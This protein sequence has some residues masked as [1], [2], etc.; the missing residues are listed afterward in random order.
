MSCKVKNAVE[1][2]KERETKM[3]SICNLSM[4]GYTGYAELGYRPTH[5]WLAVVLAK[6]GCMDPKE[7]LAILKEQTPIALKRF[8]GQLVPH[9]YLIAGWAGMRQDGVERGYLP[10]LCWVSN[11][12]DEQGNLRNLPARSFGHKIVV[13]A[14]GDGG[15]N[16][17]CIGQ[18]VRVDRVSA[19]RR[20]VGEAVSRNVGPEDVARLLV[21][22][23]QHTSKMQDDKR[24]TVGAKVSAC[25]IPRASVDQHFRGAGSA[26]MSV[27]EARVGGWFAYYDPGRD[28]FVGYAPTCTCDGWATYDSAYRA[29][30]NGD[31]RMELKFLHVPK[32]GEPGFGKPFVGLNLVEGQP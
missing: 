15:V 18:P 11:R 14:P 26:I 27:P 16:L 20:V 4:I 31:W 29:E 6:R 30:A 25:C 9:E 7:A 5:E 1:V 13:H 24:R 19:L 28:H 23:I 12:L 3:V 32:E 10:H 17:A 8:S 22:E 21:A 2:I